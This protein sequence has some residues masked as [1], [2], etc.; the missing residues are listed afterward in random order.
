LSPATWPMPF[1]RRK[2]LAR[3]TSPVSAATSSSHQRLKGT[4]VPFSLRFSTAGRRR[5]G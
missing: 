4:A 2:R 5:G 3:Q 1:A